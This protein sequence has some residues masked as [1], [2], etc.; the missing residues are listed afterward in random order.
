V[1]VTG[2]RRNS[3]GMDR[4]EHRAAGREVERDIVGDDAPGFNLHPALATPGLD[5]RLAHFGNAVPFPRNTV[6]PQAINRDPGEVVE[7]REV[8]D[9]GRDWARQGSGRQLVVGL[10]DEPARAMF[11]RLRSMMPQHKIETT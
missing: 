4:E 1:R 2:K 8:R 7:V 5:R 11:A 6:A 10:K 3:P 9:G